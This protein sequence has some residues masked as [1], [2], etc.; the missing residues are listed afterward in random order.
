[1]THSRPGPT[2]ADLWGPWAA[3]YLHHPGGL[4]RLTTRLAAAV[5]GALRTEPRAVS[6]VAGE[7]GLS[8]TTVMRLATQT[9]DVDGHADTRLVRRLGID[10]HRFRKVDRK[11]VV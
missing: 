9:L 6:G 1:M 11:S 10:E 4:T 7:H 5:T 3:G 8:W 2:L